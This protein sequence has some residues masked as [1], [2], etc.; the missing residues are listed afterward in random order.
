MKGVSNWETAGGGDREL[1]LLIMKGQELPLVSSQPTCGGGGTGAQ[2]KF[3]ASKKEDP[4]RDWRHE[5][6][7][8]WSSPAQSLLCAELTSTPQPGGGKEGRRMEGQ[9]DSHA[10][11]WALSPFTKLS[12]TLAF[13]WGPC[14]QGRSHKGRAGLAKVPSPGWPHKGRVRRLKPGVS[15]SKSRPWGFS[16][17]CCSWP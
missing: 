6:P 10:Y 16:C 8:S 12:R 13:V 17:F 7:Q 5:L 11:Q 2:V 15:C 3:S 1:H 9:R 4:G 14:S